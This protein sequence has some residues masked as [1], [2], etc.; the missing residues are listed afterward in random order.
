MRGQ[1]F[2]ALKMLQDVRPICLDNLT[3]EDLLTE[4][5][6][7]PNDR[8]G[9]GLPINFMSTDAQRNIANVSEAAL[10]NT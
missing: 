7:S 2:A 6:V 10:V 5:G 3:E 4:W 1:Y 8:R 9:R